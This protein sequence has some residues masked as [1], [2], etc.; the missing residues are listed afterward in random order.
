V[1]VV[2]IP[3]ADTLALE[4]VV[5]DFNGTLAVDGALI[6]GVRE[7]LVALGALG[8][9]HVV[10]ADTFGAAR[11]ALAGLDLQLTILDV[12]GQAQ[13]K[14]AY[15]AGCGAHRSVAIGNGR[16][17]RAMLEAAALSIAVIG[18][19]GAA[20]LAVSAAHVVAPDIRAALDLLLNPRRLAA[21][22]RR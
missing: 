7:R 6:D 21:T 20:A 9:L 1:I 22:L 17:D 18:P 16:N 8:A 13:A 19:E 5:C 12:D 2:D 10:T 4:H 14:A 15:L 3:G 11:E